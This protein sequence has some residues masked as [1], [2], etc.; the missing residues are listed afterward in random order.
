MIQMW[1]PIWLA[2][3]AVSAAATFT[4]TTEPTSGGGGG[5]FLRGINNNARFLIA[6]LATGITFVRSADAGNRA[7]RKTIR[8]GAILSSSH[9]GWKMEIG[10]KGREKRGKKCIVIR[11]WERMLV[12]ERR[13]RRSAGLMCHALANIL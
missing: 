10:G 7:L 5:V 8:G 6:V 12:W 11:L 9:R 2:S 13:R 4:S 3:A 1:I